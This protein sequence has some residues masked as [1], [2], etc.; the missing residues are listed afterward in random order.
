MKELQQV[1]LDPQS[2]VAQRE[3]AR[4][5]LAD[6]LKSPAGQVRG[7]AGR[8][9]AR[10]RRHRSV[11]ERREAAASAR[12]TAAA[13]P[14]VAHLEV[15]EPPKPVVAPQPATPPRP[16]SGFAIDPRT[17]DVLHPMPGGYI[18]P[19]T[20]PHRAALSPP[21]LGGIALEHHHL[22]DRLALVQAVEAL[23]DLVELQPPASC[24]RST[25]SRPCAVERRRSAAGRA[26]ARRCRCSCP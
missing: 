24:S 11:P 6:L 9:A 19:R 3:A 14:G 23:V 1:I 25:G 17:G 22:P 13:R 5:E 21:R 26:R 2:T 18:D 4:E 15:I 12:D 7:H 20:G 16:R 10:A 8:E